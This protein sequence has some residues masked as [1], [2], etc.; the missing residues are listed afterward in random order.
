MEAGEGPD[1]ADVLDRVRI[2]MLLAE[3]VHSPVHGCLGLSEL[4]EGEDTGIDQVDLVT[5][6]RFLEEADAGLVNLVT[7]DHIMHVDP[8]I[9][10]DRVI[11]L[12]DSQKGVR[13]LQV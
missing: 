13:E 2:W 6:D 9:G 11:E 8:C 7:V 1:G 10:L 12:A 5:K 3:F 4:E